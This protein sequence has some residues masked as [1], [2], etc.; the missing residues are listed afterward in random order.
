MSKT[1]ILT[2]DKYLQKISNLQ[3]ISALISWDQQVMM[4]TGGAAAR[5]EQI[6]T[7]HGLIH[8]QQT[9]DILKDLIEKEEKKKETDVWKKRMVE[10]ARRDYNKQIK[11][12]KELVEK[13]AKLESEAFEN[14]VKARKENNFELMV[15]Y[16]TQWIE[17][18]KEM[19][20]C[21]DDKE[22]PLNVLIDEFDPDMKM[23][24]LDELFELLK[25]N[26]IPLI[27]KIKE[28]KTKH[29]NSFLTS[30]ES[31]FDIEKQ[32]SLNKKISEKLGFSFDNG[33]LDVSTHPF[34]TSFDP[35][36]VRIT[37]RYSDKEFIQGIQGTV[38]ESGHAMYEQGLNAEYS[39]KLVGKAHG[40]SLHE[41][42]S[43]FWE[44]HIGL[45]QPFWNHYWNE[46]KETFDH[47][48]KEIS[49]TQ[50][51]N[52]IN[53]VAPTFIRVESD[54]VTYPMHIIMRYE[55]EKGLFNGTIEVKDLPKIWNEKMK[56]YLGIVPETDAL[57]VLQDIHWSLGAFGYF[58]SYL[59][60]AILA[61]QFFKTAEKKI[62]NLNEKIEKG[63][64]SELK[65]FL[66]EN[67]HSKGSLYTLDELTKQVTNESMNPKYLI[68]HL[69]KKYS[70]IY[71]LE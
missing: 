54:E 67:I 13:S 60:G 7:L 27:K 55:I 23:A 66:N 22:E 63:E 34:T 31:K 14:W 6:S 33:R 64:F 3:N 61:S 15:P 41:S 9:S 10:M 47:I 65:K 70:K 21:I 8:E 36:D 1:S 44:R 35:K 2:L 28:S 18:K 19:A 26:L 42:Q 32:K 4:P 52:A 56:E 62:E 48:P 39:T 24:R 30:E 69:T 11:I 71:N 43:L 68:D 37:T 29:E 51:Y 53:N 57:G 49:P 38:H 58:P 20:K 16:Y 45:S 59:C 40:M 5:G 46:I 50:A 12:P 25:K 17:I